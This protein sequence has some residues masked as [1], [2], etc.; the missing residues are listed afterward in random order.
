[1]RPPPSGT[2]MPSSGPS[3][4]PAMIPIPVPA[5]SDAITPIVA[6]A[7]GRDQ[8]P[9]SRDEPDGEPGHRGREHDV[10]PEGRGVRDRVAD[11]DPDDRGEVPRDEH[12][13]DGGDPVPGHVDPADPLEVRGRERERLVREHVGHR[14][15]LGERHLP[16]AR[17]QGGAV[18]RGAAG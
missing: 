1:M 17:R 9:P 6:P 18:Q 3:S 11:Q 7:T 2:A 15:P 10:E 14:G 13:H 4:P 5:A 16:D 8:L 12:E